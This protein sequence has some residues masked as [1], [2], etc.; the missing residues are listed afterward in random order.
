MMSIER[1]AR[2]KIDRLGYQKA[3]DYFM[4]FSVR[5]E[6]DGFASHHLYASAASYVKYLE[7]SRQS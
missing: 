1:V 6:H 2:E 3:Y 7:E 5:L 4:D